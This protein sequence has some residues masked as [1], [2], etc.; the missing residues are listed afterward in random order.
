[1]NINKIETAIDM[2]IT[3]EKGK[4]IQWKNRTFMEKYTT[5]DM[6]E[7]LLINTI[8]NMNIN[9]GNVDFSQ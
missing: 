6:E 3:T 1:M 5:D 2:D 4:T 8:K 7:K 9:S